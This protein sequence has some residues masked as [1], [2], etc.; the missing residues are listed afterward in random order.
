MKSVGSDIAAKNLMKRYSNEASKA[1]DGLNLQLSTKNW[2][3]ELL[4][5]VTERVT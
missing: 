1:L 2:F 3:E 5:S 4:F